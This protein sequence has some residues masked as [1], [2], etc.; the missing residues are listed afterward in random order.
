MC[1]TDRGRTC[2]ARSPVAAVSADPRRTADRWLKLT[3]GYPA[4]YS[5]VVAKAALTCLLAS[6]AAALL[7][8]AYFG[9]RAA[10]APHPSRTRRL[11]AEGLA[12]STTTLSSLR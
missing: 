2:R 9:H 11:N 6:A 5:P 10:N 4:P 3:T 8:T 7:A 12:E 1:A